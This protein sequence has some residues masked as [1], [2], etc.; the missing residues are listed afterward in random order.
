MRQIHYG[1]EDMGREGI[2]SR[3]HLLP[4]DVQWVF[5]PCANH[6]QTGWYGPQPGDGDACLSRQE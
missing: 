2:E 6:A 4:A 3:K 1:A 5:I